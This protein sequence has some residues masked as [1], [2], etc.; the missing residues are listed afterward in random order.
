MF[1]PDPDLEFSPILDPRSR[2]SK[3]HRIPDPGSATL[4]AKAAQQ[5]APRPL[6]SFYQ[7]TNHPIQPPRPPPLAKPGRTQTRVSS[8][9]PSASVIQPLSSLSR[10]LNTPHY[11]LVGNVSPRLN[12]AVVPS[13]WSLA[14]LLTS[15]F[16]VHFSEYLLRI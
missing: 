5:G 12:N 11:F 7:S 2:G 9:W 15:N 6:S 8:L 13:Y 4:P 10:F 1:I 14:V 3:K 16:S